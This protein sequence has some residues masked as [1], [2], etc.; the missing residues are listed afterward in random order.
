MTRYGRESKRTYDVESR[1]R[2]KPF[3]SLRRFASKVSDPTRCS[4]K[5]EPRALSYR[6]ELI[7]PSTRKTAVDLV[8]KFKKY[9]IKH[10][11]AGAF[12]V[13]FYGRERFSR[14]VDIVMALD[15]RGA[16]N[17]F[18]LLKSGRYTVLYPLEHEQKITGPKDLLE[19]GLVKVRDTETQSL[20]DMVLHPGEVGFKFDN[21]SERRIR[22]VSL[23]GEQVPIPSPEDYLIMKLKSRRP[24]THDFE[25]IISTLSTQFSVLDWGYLHR[26]AEEGNLTRLL[27]HYK[28]AVERKVKGEEQR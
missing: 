21:E 14:D 7:P 22:T 9:G 3:T 8:R 13:Q 11:L 24:G 10:V 4:G 16:E 19:L 18:E 28:E 17:L 6:G 23:N 20:V 12:P 1:S 15:E 2:S 26:R 5:T 27:N 25:D